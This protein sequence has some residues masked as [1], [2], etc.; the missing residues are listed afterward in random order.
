[1]KT[2]AEI[3]YHKLGSRYAY[4]NTRFL[5]IE[6][7]YFYFVTVIRT[8]FGLGLT[9]TS[10]ILLMLNLN[11]MN[12]ILVALQ[13]WCNTMDSFERT[14]DTGSCFCQFF[15]RSKLLNFS[16]ITYYLLY[17]M[18]TCFSSFQYLCLP[19]YLMLITLFVD[20]K[21]GGKGTVF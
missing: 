21:H 11:L 9:C 10:W 14:P 17:L 1:M 7:E 18:Y 20:S 6:F 16:V 3:T 2:N 5:R 12:Q 8:N 13:V 15:P 4:H 19:C